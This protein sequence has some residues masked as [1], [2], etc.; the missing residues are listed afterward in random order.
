MAV[1]TVEAPVDPRVELEKHY[2]EFC[3]QLPDHRVEIINGRIVVNPV[4]TYDHARIVFQLLLQLVGLAKERGWE[5]LTE[6][7]VFLGPQ[8]DRYRPDLIVVRPKPRMWG[9]DH[10]YGDQ[11]LLVAEVVSPS[12]VVDDHEVK[13]RHYASAGV[14]LCLVIDTLTGKVRLL[15]DPGQA[16]YRHETD[17][18]LGGLLDLP[19]P[20]KLTLD[21][22]VFTD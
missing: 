10:I 3:E 7:S 14:P 16:G 6:M 4:P 12:S 17:I 9:A 15:S 1:D 20:W 5:I 19:E 2:R 13:P 18:V 22:A 21:T 11:T 8:Q